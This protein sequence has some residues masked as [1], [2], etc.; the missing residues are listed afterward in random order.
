M[1]PVTEY[2]F[3]HMQVNKETLK[4]L[5]SLLENQQITERMV[6][7]LAGI[8]DPIKMI[9]SIPEKVR[10]LDNNIDTDYSD[11][12]FLRYDFLQNQVYFTYVQTDYRIFRTQEDAEKYASTGDYNYGSSKSTRKPTEEYPYVGMREIKDRKTYTTYEEWVA[13]AIDLS[14]SKEGQENNSASL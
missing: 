9:A 7:A 6:Y 13:K 2:V 14:T 8:Y 12:T 10:V 3:D 5:L 11:C 1:D 4:Y